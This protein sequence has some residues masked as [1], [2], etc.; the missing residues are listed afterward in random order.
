MDKFFSIEIL[1]KS[2]TNSLNLNS[3]YKNSQVINILCLGRKLIKNRIE[4]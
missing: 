3:F 2:Y 4:I 1:Q